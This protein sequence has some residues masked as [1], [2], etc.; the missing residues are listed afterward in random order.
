MTMSDALNYK[1]R[2]AIELRL[3]AHEASSISAEAHRELAGRYQ[4][5]ATSF[6]LVNQRRLS[7]D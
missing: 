5:L 3:A 4:K 7:V 1:K 6:A 2:A